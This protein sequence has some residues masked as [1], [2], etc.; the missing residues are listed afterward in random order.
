M[1]SA[2]VEGTEA[3]DLFAFGRS[4]SA[5]RIM[6]EPGSVTTNGATSRTCPQNRGSEGTD[7]GTRETEEPGSR[8]HATPIVLS[9]KTG[10]AAP[11]VDDEADRD[12]PHH[13]AADVE[14][15]HR[16]PGTKSRVWQLRRVALVAQETFP[17]PRRTS[18]SVEP[19]P[20][21]GAC[22]PWSW[23][24]AR[25]RRYRRRRTPRSGAYSGT[26]CRRR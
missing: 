20:T 3:R 8:D 10:R 16:D 24:S 21:R 26:R 2:R 9:S 7:M 14:L 12:A 13:S 19:T 17:T 5:K 23:S 22:A 15:G 1:R 25:T 11:L 6:A 18:A 4:Q